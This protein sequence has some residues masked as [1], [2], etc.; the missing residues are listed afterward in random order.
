M[1]RRGSAWMGVPALFWFLIFL[2]GPLVQ[3]FILSFWRRG[4]YGGVEQIWEFDNYLR[5]WGSIYSLILLR[6]FLLALL[7]GLLCILLALPLA[8]GITS[9]S[10]KQKKM[11]LTF[12]AVPFFM[13][14]IA[15]VYALKSFL[16]TEGPLAHILEFLGWTGDALQ[17][18]QNF[19]LVLYGLV[20]TYLPFL[21]L[22]VWVQLE[23]I[24]P[25][26][27]EAALDLGE[28]PFRSFYKVI[29]P[30]LRPALASGLLLVIVPVLGEYVIPDL[31][32][33][34]KTMLAGNVISEQFL[35]A[36]DWPFG[37]ALAIELIGILGL[38]SFVILSWGKGGMKS[39]S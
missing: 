4:A 36:R 5:S 29:L 38:S 32:G 35:K 30:Q 37:A 34:A 26:Q 13:N 3:V 11:I 39:E 7:T 21:L 12:L 1:S 24:D 27:M 31:L 33:G 6:S 9:F 18:S 8:W 19:P 15:R 28:T 17:L 20:V 23:K 10:S 22:P 16:H 2:L 14:L 25:T